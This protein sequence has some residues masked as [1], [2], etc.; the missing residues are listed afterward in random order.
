MTQHSRKNTQQPLSE[1]LEESCLQ[2]HI[3][4]NS[5]QITASDCTS[6]SENTQGAM[7]LQ[8]LTALHWNSKLISSLS[9]ANVSKER[10]TVTVGDMK[11][12]KHLGVPSKQPGADKVW[13]HYC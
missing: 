10:L 5:G 3:I 8:K 7:N 12:M 4:L 11:E 9:N 6:N 13:R 1:T 2:F